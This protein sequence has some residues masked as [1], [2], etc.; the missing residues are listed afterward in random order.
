MSLWFSVWFNGIS[1]M[2]YEGIARLYIKEKNIGHH[3]R[4]LEVS[5]CVPG[6]LSHREKAAI[7]LV[8]TS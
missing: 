6:K 2:L 1:M 3:N 8:C 4:F 7:F 5:I